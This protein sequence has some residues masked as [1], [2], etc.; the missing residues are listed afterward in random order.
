MISVKKNAKNIGGKINLDI[1]SSAKKSAIDAFNFAQESLKNHIPHKES[2]LI[3][4]ADQSKH[5]IIGILHEIK[6][7]GATRKKEIEVFIFNTNDKTLEYST[8]TRSFTYRFKELGMNYK[9][10]KKLIDIEGFRQTRFLRE[11]IG[12][13]SNESVRKKIGELNEKIRNE[14]KLAKSFSLITSDPGASAGYRIN[15]EIKIQVID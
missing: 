8:K 4:K 9:L 10:V 2:Q 11:D 1:I 13:K 14:F 3:N 7:Q 5:E 6:E 12:S 15:P